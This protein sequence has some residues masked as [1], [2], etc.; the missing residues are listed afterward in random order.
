M[1]L[2]ELTCTMLGLVLSLMWIPFNI[3]K[4]KHFSFDAFYTVH[5]TG[6]LS[7]T[8]STI[9]QVAVSLVIII[10]MVVAVIILNVAH[11]KIRLQVRGQQILMLERKTHIIVIAVCLLYT[12]PSPRD[13]TLSRMPSSA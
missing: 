4:Q 2:T 10:E 12:S 11:Y 3:M 13:A 8:E 5:A 1:I 7:D 9:T 6:C